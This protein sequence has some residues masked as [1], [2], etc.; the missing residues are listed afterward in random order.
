MANNLESGDNLVSATLRTRLNNFEIYI[1]DPIR[2]LPLY[3]NNAQSTTLKKKLQDQLN[4]NTT[5]IQLTADLS[6][7]LAKR[8]LELERQIKEL[9]KIEYNDVPQELRNK[10]TDLEKEDRFI[11]QNS[12]KVALGLNLPNVFVPTVPA[13]EKS[14]TSTT[15]SG[16]ASK[17]DRITTKSQIGIEFA[18][19]IGQGLLQEVRRLQALLHEKEGITKELEV[20]KAELERTIEQLNKNLRAHQE[21]KVWALELTKLDLNAQLEDLQQQISKSRSDYA[22]IEKALTT[23]TDIIEQLK[24]K[25]IKLTSAL[26]TATDVIEQFK[27]KEERLTSNLKILFEKDTGKDH[28]TIDDLKSQLKSLLTVSGSNSVSYMENDKILNGDDNDSK[29]SLELS[30]ENPN[31]GIKTINTLDVANCVINILCDILK[32]DEVHK[33]KM[34]ADSQEQDLFEIMHSEECSDATPKKV[35]KIQDGSSTTFELSN[36]AKNNKIEND[37][38]DEW[39]II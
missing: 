7:A 39:E 28:K 18:T 10:L 38:S 16:R 31:V 9:D 20:E 5:Q 35:Q 34:L 17:R 13:V 25:E 37:R 12:A 4:E 8:R 19:E 36:A 11:Y 32:K 3:I 29:I 21:S 2:H 15:S 26:S 30:N 27:E 14:T 22:K 23:A 1:S 6:T 24:E 33:L